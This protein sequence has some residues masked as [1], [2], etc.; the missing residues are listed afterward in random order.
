MGATLDR[1]LTYEKHIEKVAQNL[2]TRNSILK[3]LDETSWGA[4]QTTLKTSALALCY[5]TA[6]YCAPVWE[7]NKHTKRIDT[8]LYTT[9]RILSGTLKLTP[10]VWLSAMATIVSLHLRRQALT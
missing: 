7:R 6:E 1:T 8:Q 4:H 9:M 3:K 10:T 5:G 2:K